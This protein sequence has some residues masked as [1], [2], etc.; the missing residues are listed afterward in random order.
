MKKSIFFLLLIQISPAEE[1]RPWWVLSAREF[2]LSI[3]DRGFRRDLKEVPRNQWDFWHFAAAWMDEES[4]RNRMKIA[5]WY[6]EE[7]GNHTYRLPALMLFYEP[8]HP[9]GFKRD[10]ELMDFLHNHFHE[11]AVLGLFFYRAA[12]AVDR[13][14]PKVTMEIITQKLYD[15]ETLHTPELGTLIF[16][17]FLLAHEWG[18]TRRDTI[19]ALLLKIWQR[20]IL[21]D[22]ELYARHQGFIR[23]VVSFYSGYG[24][25]RSPVDPDSINF[26]LARHHLFCNLGTCGM[27]KALKDL[28]VNFILPPKA[29]TLPDS[30]PMQDPIPLEGP[31]QSP[32]WTKTDKN[33]SKN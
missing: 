10:A 3:K 19:R 6:Y 12:V 18:R 2:V 17:D 15:K 7:R 20:E 33:R 4:D 16:L 30:F 32:F 9:P 14:F 22:T 8:W 1:T 31:P 25:G 27:G 28:E 26:L 29:F 5:R 23:K 13:L 11:P 21:L 24:M